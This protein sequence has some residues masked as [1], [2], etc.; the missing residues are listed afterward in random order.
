MA[1]V[2]S[3]K[4]SVPRSRVEAMPGP[5][6]LISDSETPLE[7]AP[8]RVAALRFV[9]QS[10]GI[11]AG[12]GKAPAA[13]GRALGEG[14][15]AGPARMRLAADAGPGATGVRPARAPFEATCVSVLPEATRRVA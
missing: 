8:K 6:Q 4:R 10:A 3:S 9:A 13:H 1:S 15:I 7:F 11:G 14:A 12:P 2:D 5:V